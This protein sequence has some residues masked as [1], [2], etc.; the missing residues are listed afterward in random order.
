MLNTINSIQSAIMELEGGAFQK[1]F[2]AYLYKKYKF[3]NLKLQYEI[4]HSVNP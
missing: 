1:L 3:K 4:E 2:D